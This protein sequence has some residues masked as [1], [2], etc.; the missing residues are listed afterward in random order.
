MKV[1]LKKRLVARTG[2]VKSLDF[3]PTFSWIL[4]GLYNGSISIYDYNTQSSVQYLEVSPLPIRSAK[5]MPEKNY[6]ICGSDDKKIRIYNYNTM[7]KIKEYEAHTDFIRSIAVHFKLPIFI[8]SSDDGTINLYDAEKDFKLIRTYNEHKDFVMELAVNPKD[9]AMFASA[10]SDKKIK[11]WSFMTNNSQMTLEGHLKGVNTVAFCSLNDK[12]YLASGGDDFIIKVWD[13]TNKHCIFTF[14]GHEGP[15]TSVCFH[16]EIPILITASEDQTSKFYNINTSKLED[17]KIFG[18]DI[19]WDIKAYKE[20]N[21]IGFGCDEATIVVQMGSDEPLITF[22]QIQ[23]KIIYAQQNNIFSLNLKQVSHETKDGEIINIPPKQL[24]S[25][26]LFPNKIQY[27]PN[28]RYF[29][30][31][32]DKEFIISTSGV[33][34]S[35]AVGNCYDLSWNENDSF[36]IK[37]GNTVKI[38]KD[39]KEIKN[40]KPGFSFENIFGGPLFSIKTE[41]SIYMYDIE[42]TILIRKIEVIPNKIIWNDKKNSVALICEDVT[43][44]LKVNFNKI[45]EYIEKCIDDGE[46]DEN[47]C[48]EAFGESYDIDEKIINGFY[49]ENVFIYQT[50]KNKINYSIN[51]KIFNITTLSSNYFIL[52]YLES[53]NKIYLM[54][55]GFQLISYTLPYSFIMYQIAILSKQFD[56]AENL[57]SKIPESFNERVISFLQKFNYNDLCYKITKNPNQKFSLALKLK[58]LNDA[59]EIANQTKNSEKF[60]MVADLAFELGEFNYAE[61]AMKEAKDFS[62]LLLYY[63]SIQNREK[64]K[65]LGEESKKIGLFNISFS[66]FFILNDIDNCFNLLIESKRFPEAAIFCRTYY[67]SKLNEVIELWNDEINQIDKNTRMTIKI[68]NPV[69]DENKEILENAELKNNELYKNVSEASM[70]D[71]NKYLELYNVSSI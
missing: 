51:E 38:Y 21:I 67:P 33:Y 34:R 29:S 65:E 22:N 57:L 7:E 46:I 9:Y 63:S 25:S 49:I 8:S 62:G 4:L 24:G 27:S 45:E 41:D 17:S 42:N 43:Y 13:Y 52:G 69:S 35:S 30:I 47:G 48:E 6:I 56:K 66:T 1:N 37:E 60:K 61:K 59:Y 39:L 64:L 50:A 10:S 31:L 53:T 68:V 54:N 2:K 71:L 70:N 32:S 5:F 15:I 23:S 14:E 40:F 36:V 28:G 26:E 58:L 12:P 20:N 11:I 44:I 19:I 16:P 18:Y 55:K 3:H